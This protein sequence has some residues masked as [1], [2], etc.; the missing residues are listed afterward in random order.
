MARPNDYSED[1]VNTP[2]LESAPSFAQ[3]YQYQPP[4]FSGAAQAQQEYNNY[5]PMS[6]L[7]SYSV[8]PAYL[9]SLATDGGDFGSLIEALLNDADVDND[10]ADDLT[11]NDVAITIA[12][13]DL[14]FLDRLESPEV[15]KKRVPQGKEIVIPILESTEAEDAVPAIETGTGVSAESIPKYNNSSSVFAKETAQMPS[16]NYIQKAKTGSTTNTASLKSKMSETAAIQSVEQDVLQTSKH[17]ADDTD[18]DDDNATSANVSDR[19]KRNA[20]QAK[21]NRE[22]KKAYITGL[23]N[24][25]KELTDKNAKLCSELSASKKTI[26]SLQEE[27]LYLKNVITNDSALSAVL[28]SVRASKTDL[29]TSFEVSRK[30]ANDSLCSKE[31]ASKRVNNRTL[32]G[33]GICLH[34]ENSN[35]SLEFCRSCSKMANGD[36]RDQT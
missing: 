12:D 20:I 34:V 23:E 31:P 21:I 8:D 35:V 9:E 16:N 19:N 6:R 32:I 13:K 18:A 15:E 29:S 2:E 1:L 14:A 11:A 28:Q 25:V 17:S 33:G 22:R 24:D 7:D 27:I 3:L 26:D 36:G 10:L 4:Q 5:A 30:R